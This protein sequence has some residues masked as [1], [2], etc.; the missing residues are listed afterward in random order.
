[1]SCSYPIGNDAVVTA[2]SGV[3]IEDRATHTNTALVRN[4]RWSRASV[5][6]SRD[7]P[8]SSPPPFYH[9]S[10]ALAVSRACNVQQSRPRSGRRRSRASVPRFSGSLGNGDLNKKCGGAIV[11]RVPLFFG[12]FCRVAVEEGRSFE[13]AA[14]T[15]GLVTVVQIF[16]R[17]A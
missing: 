6:L 13:V 11:L 14:G 5:A 10:A 15:D 12:G 16:C 9:R 17:V 1:M 2:A 3:I 8:L 7:D 4:L